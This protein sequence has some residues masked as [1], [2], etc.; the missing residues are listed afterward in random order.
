MITRLLIIIT[1][2][3]P[4][5]NSI[6]TRNITN[7]RCYIHKSFFLTRYES[8]S[9]AQRVKNPIP[10]NFEPGSPG[11]HAT[12]PTTLTALNI[13]EVTRNIWNNIII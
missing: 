4:K 13:L 11:D 6:P 2:N 9:K 7:G 12:Y 1:C 10:P 8:T 5:L 3:L